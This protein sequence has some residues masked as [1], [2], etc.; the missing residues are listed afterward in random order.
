MRSGGRPKSLN[1]G[2]RWVSTARKGGKR[3]TKENKPKEEINPNTVYDS[4]GDGKADLVGWILHAPT[5]ECPK[6][7]ARTIVIGVLL[8]IGIKY[9]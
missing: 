7:L 6:W 9:S 8:F 3:K 1:S 2:A 5:P 4:N